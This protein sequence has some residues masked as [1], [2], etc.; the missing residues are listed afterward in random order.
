MASKTVTASIHTVKYI[1]VGISVTYL[2]LSCEDEIIP[3]VVNQSREKSSLM[4]LEIK[5]KIRNYLDFEIASNFCQNKGYQS[6]NT[7]V[8]FWIC[9]SST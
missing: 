8:M 3:L 6:V 9:L 5:L 4:S 2:L 7:F 1:K